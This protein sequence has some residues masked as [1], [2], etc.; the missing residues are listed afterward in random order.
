[1]QISLQFHRY[2]FFVLE[3]V[4]LIPV[5]LSF[6]LLG[7]CLLV[8]LFVAIYSCHLCAITACLKLLRK[9]MSSALY[10]KSGGTQRQKSLHIWR[11]AW[12]LHHQVV[13]MAMMEEEGV[14][15]VMEEE[16]I[17]AVMEGKRI[18][19]LMEGEGNAAVMEGEVDTMMMVVT[20]QCR[21]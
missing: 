17:T 15:A 21:T 5:K 10:A 7:D 16:W 11:S 18:T 12:Q 13:W 4:M 20:N 8:V 14:M 9:R 19:A 2:V 6:L 3:E 1:V